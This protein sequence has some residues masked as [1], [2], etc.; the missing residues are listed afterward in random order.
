MMGGGQIETAELKHT[1]KST[2][3]RRGSPR[4]FVTESM[5]ANPIATD[6]RGRPTPER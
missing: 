6:R 1:L 4:A 5:S 2:L 3:V